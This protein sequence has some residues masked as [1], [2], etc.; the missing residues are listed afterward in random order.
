MLDDSVSTAIV[1]E[2]Y[3]HS[4][5]HPDST[6][7]QTLVIIIATIVFTFALIG[8]YAVLRALYLLIKRRRRT[9]LSI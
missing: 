4:L 3:H 2:A 5:A 8:I 1:N 9:R 6:K 7:Y